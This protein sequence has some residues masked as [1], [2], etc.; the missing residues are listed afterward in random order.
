VAGKVRYPVRGATGTPIRS[1]SVRTFV[2]RTSRTPGTFGIPATSGT[3]FLLRSS[4]A[5]A[6]LSAACGPRRTGQSHHPPAR[7]QERGGC[8]CTGSAR[9]D[10]EA[11]RTNRDAGA[12]GGTAA[13]DAG[14]GIGGVAAASQAAR[15]PARTPGRAGVY[16]QSAHPVGF[17]RARRTHLSELAARTDARFRA[18]LRDDPR[19]DAPSAPRPLTE[20]LGT[21]RR[22]VSRVSGGASMAARKRARSALIYGL[23]PKLPTP[24]SQEP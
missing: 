17:M 14:A 10:L 7:I 6:A 11:A 18:R 4:S 13:F 8:V 9:M 2:L 16:P 20:I 24:N 21:C 5:C 19:A 15:G 1:D 3:E 22:R 23:T 12:H